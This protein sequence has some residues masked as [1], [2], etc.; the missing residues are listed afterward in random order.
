MPDNNIQFLLGQLA[1][2]VKPIPKMSEDLAEMKGAVTGLP[3]N[4]HT[5]S[6][7]GLADRVK[8]VEINRAGDKPK[9]ALL[10]QILLWILGAGAM[11][12]AGLV[13]ANGGRL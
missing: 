9:L 2:A 4:E 1:E 3:C 8:E 10:W 11:F 6:I 12:A 7:V 5:E 13:F